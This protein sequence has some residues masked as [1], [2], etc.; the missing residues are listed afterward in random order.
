MDALVLPGIF[1][2]SYRNAFSRMATY[3]QNRVSQA[4]TLGVGSTP[5]NF[6]TGAT[7]NYTVNGTALTKTA[8][9]NIAQPATTTGSGEYAKDL[10]VIDAAGTFAV[11]GG[12]KASSQTA[13]KLPEVPAG[14]VAVGYIAV[15]PNFTPGTSNVTADMLVDVVPGQIAFA[16]PTVS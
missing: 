3:S 6:K 4:G 15:P 11:V 13:A 14:K 12:A 1:D 7:L 8:T 10:I 2:Q 16:P 5:T 9:Q